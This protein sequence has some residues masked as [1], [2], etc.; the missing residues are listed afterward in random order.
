MFFKL[1]RQTN[2]LESAQELLVVAAASDALLGIEKLLIPSEWMQALK[3]L[4]PF[5]QIDP[6]YAYK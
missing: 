2:L 6:F 1:S 5:S 4:S 3:R